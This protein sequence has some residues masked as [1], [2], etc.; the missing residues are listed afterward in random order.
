MRMPTPCQQLKLEQL[1]FRALA[2]HLWNWLPQHTPWRG[3]QGA[4]ALGRGGGAAGGRRQDHLALGARQ[5]LRR[6]HDARRRLPGP[7]AP[8]LPLHKPESAGS[9]AS[10]HTCERRY[11]VGGMAGCAMRLQCSVCSAATWCDEPADCRSA[12]S[13]P[14]DS[15][16]D[17]KAGEAHLLLHL[18]ALD[19]LAR[20]RQAGGTPCSSTHSPL[21]PPAVPYIVD[22]HWRAAAAAAVSVTARQKIEEIFQDSPR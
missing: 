12:E 19:S 3:A 11:E 5:R 14:A 15:A 1:T 13:R 8:E 17:D 7:R 16:Q 2:V 4:W 20:R 9:S 6:H 21:I 10:R 22:H 18:A